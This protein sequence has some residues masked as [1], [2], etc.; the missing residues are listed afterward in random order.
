MGLIEKPILRLNS[1]NF[2]EAAKIFN[3]DKVVNKI[4]EEKMSVWKKVIGEIYEERQRILKM[5]VED[6]PKNEWVYQMI[7]NNLDKQMKS[8][9]SKYRQVNFHYL[10]L[11]GKKRWTKKNIDFE[12]L[13]KLPIIDFVGTSPV[14]KRGD[15]WMYKCVFHNEK[16]PSMQINIKKNLFYC[17]GCGKSGSVID[18]IMFKYDCNLAEAIKVLIS[19]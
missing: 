10:W 19:Y 4:M 16:T 15:E 7:L 12:E 6:E 13:R 1:L 11:T 17:F 2:R 18:F 9:Q 8:A 14:L 3:Q 5:S